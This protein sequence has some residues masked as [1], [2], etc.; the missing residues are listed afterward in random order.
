MK[1]SRFIAFCMALFFTTVSFAQTI[2]VAGTVTDSSNEPVI[3]ASVLVKGTTT[4]N[5][6]SPLYVIDGV[7]TRAD[8]D[9]LGS[10][11]NIRRYIDNEANNIFKSW[12]I[13]GNAY[14]DIT[15]VKGLVLRSNFGVNYNPDYSNEFTPAW[16]EHTRSYSE[17]ALDISMTETLEWVWTNTATYS[18]HSVQSLK[19]SIYSESWLCCILVNFS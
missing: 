8:V 5:N 18:S 7:M 3:G 17:S 15:P 13:F 14:I 19:G 4:I 12:R 9:L 6:S 1:R 2:K 16:D 11:Q 10:R